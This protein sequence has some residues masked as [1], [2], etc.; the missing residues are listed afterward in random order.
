MAPFLSSLSLGGSKQ[1]LF[2]GF[3]QKFQ[4]RTEYGYTGG[5]QDFPIP[6]RSKFI[7]VKIWGGGGYYGPYGNTGTDRAGGAAA[8][9]A[10][11]PVQPG[12]NAQV[13]VANRGDNTRGGYGYGKGG[14]ST[15]GNIYYMSHGRRRNGY[16]GG[17]GG[18]SS[19]VYAP[20]PNVLMRCGGGGGAGG[21]GFPG[22]SNNANVLSDAP[23]PGQGGPGPTGGGQSGQQGGGGGGGYGSNNW[24]Q[25][26][27]PG[28]GGYG[29]PSSIPGPYSGFP[30]NQG[31]SSQRGTSGNPNDPDR[32]GSYGGWGQRGRV[33]IYYD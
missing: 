13:W 32:Q 3:K 23:G 19:A 8:I 4:L 16:A 6:S 31:Y 33:I 10:Y 12:G 2:L 20:G 11:M 24:T 28:R 29:G 21:W 7:R 22:D 5:R 9:D 25:Y 26:Q 18:G 30:P 27:G 14:G 17:G 15:D 1:G